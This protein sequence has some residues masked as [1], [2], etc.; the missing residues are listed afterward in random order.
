MERICI[1]SAILLS[2]PQSNK[3]CMPVTNIG[4]IP[5]RAVDKFGTYGFRNKGH[6]L[7]REGYG[8]QPVNK[9]S[10]KIRVPHP[11]D[12]L[13]LVAWVGDHDS[14][15]LLKGTGFSP[16]GWSFKLTVTDTNLKCYFNYPSHLITVPLR[17]IW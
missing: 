2:Y 1:H 12:V 8:L 6:G 16:R 9:T 15:R 10:T 3:L 13:V 11:C 17:K 14:M 5:A 4:S 7:Q